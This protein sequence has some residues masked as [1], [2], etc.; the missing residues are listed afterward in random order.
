MLKKH[1]NR[2]HKIKLP[3][4]SMKMTNQKK[5][6]I[7]QLEMK[8]NGLSLL[9]STVYSFKKKSNWKKQEDKNLKLK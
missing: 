4:R 3:R 8:M 9:N 7:K 2:N 5:V 1:R 6:F